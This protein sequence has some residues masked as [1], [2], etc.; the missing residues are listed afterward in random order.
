MLIPE[1]KAQLETVMETHRA[2]L[3]SGY[4]GTFL[5]NALGEKYKRVAKELM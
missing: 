5:P 3:A 4:A 1:L 2:D